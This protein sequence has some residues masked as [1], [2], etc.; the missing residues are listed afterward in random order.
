MSSEDKLDG[1]LELLWRWASSAEEDDCQATRSLRH[2][3]RGATHLDSAASLIAQKCVDALGGEDSPGLNRA[4]ELLAALVV[5][6]GEDSTYRQP[7]P[8]DTRRRRRL[9]IERGL[10]T[11]LLDVAVAG[12]ARHKHSIKSY[13]ASLR[14]AIE[15]LSLIHI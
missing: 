12:A 9:R 3:L 13:E 6:S 10:K 5:A 8:V 4:A 14:L 1:G 15:L 2:L 7:S 11:S